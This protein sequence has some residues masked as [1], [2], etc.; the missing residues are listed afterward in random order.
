MGRP[1]ASTTAWILLLRPPCEAPSFCPESEASIDFFFL[2]APDAQ[3]AALA[4]VESLQRSQSSG[5]LE[6]SSNK[7]RSRPVL[8]LR[9]NRLRALL[10]LPNSMGKSRLGTLAFKNRSRALKNLRLASSVGSRP[11]RPW[12]SE[13]RSESARHCSSLGPWRRV[14]VSFFKAM[15]VLVLRDA[16]E[17]ISARVELEINA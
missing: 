7:R 14:D 6:I 16:K 4:A 5:E 11:R 13:T 2:R 3:G 9:M 1:S 10:D 8:A 17:A 12:M 15:R